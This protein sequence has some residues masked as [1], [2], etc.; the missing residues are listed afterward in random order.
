[1]YFCPCPCDEPPEEPESRAFVPILPRNLSYVQESYIDQY[2]V[3][4]NFVQ[5]EKTERTIRFQQQ[6]QLARHVTQELEAYLSRDHHYHGQGQGG[7]SEAAGSPG[8]TPACPGGVGGV[9][10]AGDS[11]NEGR[12]LLNNGFYSG[13]ELNL[14]ETRAEVFDKSCPLPVEGKTS[15]D[16]ISC[17]TNSP[18]L[19]STDTD[20]YADNGVVTK[21]SCFDQSFQQAYTVISENSNTSVTT[22]N[23]SSSSTHE[24][25]G[26]D[27]DIPSTDLSKEEPDLSSE[28]IDTQSFPSSSLF[29]DAHFPGLFTPLAKAASRLSALLSPPNE[30]MNDYRNP[31]DDIGSSVDGDV[32]VTKDDYVKCGD[33]IVLIDEIDNQEVIVN[34]DQLPPVL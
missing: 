25:E 21:E 12:E 32:L 29:G 9:G 7:V 16:Y 24:E 4:G 17:P 20:V 33:Y 3:S 30:C 18:T 19:D 15:R 34:V 11:E 27:K 28:E 5:N 23:N 6:Q 10:Y 22:V 2:S 1:M 31:G 13:N 14:V 8:V 26:I